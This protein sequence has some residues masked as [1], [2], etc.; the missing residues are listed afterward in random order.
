MGGGGGVANDF[1]GLETHD[2]NGV[3]FMNPK[4]RT[5]GSTSS[6]QVWG[7][8]ILK[9][10][11]SSYQ[12]NSQGQRCKK[13]GRVGVYVIIPLLPGEGKEFASTFQINWFSIS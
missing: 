5:S 2:S 9:H 3:L 10:L 12:E 8:L 11:F 1:G 13:Q 6:L 4:F 7:Q